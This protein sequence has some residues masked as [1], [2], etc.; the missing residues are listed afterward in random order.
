VRQPAAA[1]QEPDRGAH[2]DGARGRTEHGRGAD[3]R[4]DRDAGQHAVPDRL[5]EKGHAARDDPRAD[6]SAD[7]RDEDPPDERAQHEVGREGVEKPGH[8]TP[9]YREMRTIINYGG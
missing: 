1:L 3:E 8:E 2:D 4:R 6:D 7:P 5:A 9:L